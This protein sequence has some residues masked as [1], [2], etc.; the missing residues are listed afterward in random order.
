[1]HYSIMLSLSHMY[2]IRKMWDQVIYSELKTFN[3]RIWKQLKLHDNFIKE[4]KEQGSLWIG[5]RVS[6]GVQ[7][8]V[9]TS[10]LMKTIRKRRK[11]LI[12]KGMEWF[13]RQIQLAMHL[14]TSTVNA[15]YIETLILCTNAKNWSRFL[16]VS[17]MAVIYCFILSIFKTTHGELTESHSWQKLGSPYTS[18]CNQIQDI[19]HPAQ[20]TYS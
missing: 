4:S 5:S 9:A 11:T 2:T 6:S 12:R 17:L 14:T 1:M 8:R 20:I 3:S 13:F 16:N 19:K 18:Y 10:F 15:I 7:G